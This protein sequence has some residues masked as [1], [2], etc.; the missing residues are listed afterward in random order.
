M[1]VFARMLVRK[2][3]VT[4]ETTSQTFDLRLDIWPFYALAW[5]GIV[6]ATVLLAVRLWRLMRPGVPAAGAKTP[7]G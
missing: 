4:Y 6:A 3:V 2:I 7:P 5:I 1:A